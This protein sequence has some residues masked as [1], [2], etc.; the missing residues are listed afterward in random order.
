MK[1]KPG[2]ENV[3]TYEQIKLLIKITDKLNSKDK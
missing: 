1:N 3:E 2:N